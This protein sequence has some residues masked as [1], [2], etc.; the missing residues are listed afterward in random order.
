[1]YFIY[2]FFSNTPDII[3]LPVF[4]I[5]LLYNISLYKFYKVDFLGIESTEGGIIFFISF[6]SEL[7]NLA[8][9]TF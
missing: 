5:L 4:S 2:S 7:S 6:C 1:M 8:I 3:F 9:I